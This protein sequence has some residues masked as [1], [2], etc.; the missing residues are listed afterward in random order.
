M[1]PI[2][3]L[4]TGLNVR[5]FAIL[6]CLCLNVY[7]SNIKGIVYIDANVNGKVDHSEKGISRIAVSDGLNVVL[8]DT[9]GFF[10]LPG[11]F[12]SR[13]VFI[14]VPA[15]YRTSQRHYLKIDNGIS[16]YDF[17]LLPFPA[18]AKKITRFIQLADTETNEDNGWIN[19]IREYAK[20]EEASFIV[21]T[22]DICYEKGLNF[23][24]LNLTSETMGIP[25]FYCIGNHD[26]VKGEFGE[27]L[28][29]K[30]FG[31]VYYSFEAGNTHYLVTPML[32]G[33]YRP[34]YTKEDVFRWMKND[35]KLVDPT[36]SVV[37]F[38]HDLLT[39]GD[40]FIYGISEKEQINLNEHNLKAWIYGHW[41]INYMKQHGKTGIVSICASPPN[42]G[43]IDHSASNFVVYE[44]NEKGNLSIHP[45]YNY[46]KNHFA[47]I[48]PNGK[49]SVVDKNN[50]LVIAVNFY[51][52]GSSAQKIEF[53]VDD[54]KH[55]IPLSPQTDWNWTGTVPAD[56]LKVGI[57]HQIRFR[58]T[59]KNGDIVSSERDFV[60]HDTNPEI[61]IED[62]WTNL[63]GNPQ[64]RS[65]STE[66]QIDGLQL[67]WMKNTG[68]NIWM[69]SPVYG[70]GK[71]FIAT[72]DEFAHQNNHIIAYDAKTGDL[73]WKYKTESSVKN[74]ICL[75][76]GRVL[77]TDEE[78]IAYAINAENGLLIWKKEL[79]HDYLGACVTGSVVQN[80]ILYT[81]FGNYLS[82]MNSTDGTTI[83]KNNGW[84]GGEGTTSTYTVAGN[85][86]IAGSN[87]RALYGHN[88]QTGEKLW[89]LSQDGLRFRSG[90]ALWFDDTLFVTAEK[91]LIKMNPL[92]GKIYNTLPLSYDFQVAATPLVTEKRIVL[93]TST[94]GVVAF[95]RHTMKE[96][97]KVKTGSSLIYTVGYSKPF[98]STV[99]ASPLLVGN[100][101]IFGASD[102]C[103]YAVDQA[104]G[105]I[106]EKIE[107][108]SPILGAACKSGN[109][110]Y[111]A[112]FSGNI[113]CFALTISRKME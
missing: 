2:L 79:G 18:S 40:Q 70:D 4:I 58:A 44:M 65:T 46:L 32:N 42:M 104:D 67:A 94:D 69:G 74:S 36:K 16:S 68:S 92:T 7:A 37:V 5:M 10:E 9:N 109:V 112:D 57:P 39:F 75:E 96:L 51:S 86:L 54:G 47:V 28:F 14:T 52:T 53:Q 19:P 90:T 102:G 99:E 59:M 64:H 85:V 34:S 27:Q 41:H 63:L 50:Q 13:F 8:T 1:T 81:G 82:A 29:E 45:R 35:L 76:N 62:N 93:S 101:I 110:I 87:W 106:V 105:A 60:I 23:H 100:L 89:E 80:G 98:S 6:F 66:A 24:A 71:V 33:D 15:G 55:W 111:V 88:L 61:I 38:N 22:G 49:Q 108:G 83:W 48:S 17:G 77:A 25:V 84:R 12:K 97:W 26:L 72:I 30:N 3:K 20:N 95:D 21:H 107:L 103:L 78:G 73:L 43:G 56:R 11:T 91:N 31:P 113:Y